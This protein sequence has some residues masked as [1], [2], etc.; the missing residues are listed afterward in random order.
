MMDSYTEGENGEMTNRRS[1][2]GKTYNEIVNER[3]RNKRKCTRSQAVGEFLM[4]LYECFMHFLANLKGWAA[5]QR[6][7][8]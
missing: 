2:S 3:A 8:S 6:S 1:I 5:I 7:I 4:I